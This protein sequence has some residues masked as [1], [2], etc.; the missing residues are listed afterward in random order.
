MATCLSGDLVRC[1]YCLLSVAYV[2][3]IN[4]QDPLA[5]ERC[6]YLPDL[7]SAHI[8][9]RRPILSSSFGTHSTSITTPVLPINLAKVNQSFPLTAHL[10]LSMTAT[11]LRIWF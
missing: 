5:L 8:G 10:F 9:L 1:S 2:S 11:S 7:R 3:D 6:P 4:D